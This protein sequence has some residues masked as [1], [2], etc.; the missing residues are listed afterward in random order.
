LV[1]NHH[2]NPNDQRNNEQ[3][4]PASPADSGVEAR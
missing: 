2:T 1:R 4:R 3:N